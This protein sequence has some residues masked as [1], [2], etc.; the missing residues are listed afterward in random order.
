MLAMDE[1]IF[2]PEKVVVI[3]FVTFG[4]ELQNL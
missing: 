2:Q 4:V 3:V 1:S